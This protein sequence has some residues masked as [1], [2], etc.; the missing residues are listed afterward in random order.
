MT[1]TSPVT[2]K[3]FIDSMFG[4]NAFVV[5]SAN[6]SGGRAGWVID[7]GLGD[8]VQRLLDYIAREGIGLEKIL[9]THGHADHIAGLDAVHEAH[10]HAQVFMADADQPML[11][12]PELNL[13]A[14]F[15]FR[16]VM[17]TPANGDITPRQVMRLG[18]VDW[19]ALDTSGH[20][21]GGRSFYCAEAGVVLTGDA[22]FAGSIGRTDLP[23]S[24]SKQL[25]MNI[26]EQLLT[27]PP[28]TMVYS[29]LGPITTIGNERKLNRFL[30]DAY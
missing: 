23:G 19:T 7:P 10:P 28:E 15:G 24:D 9:L 6:G 4:E 26:H 2:I 27:L 22:L 16:V 12:D 3:A 1:T 18:E 30:S 25:L 14:P 5:S 20:S 29:G 8:Q 21:P 17:E 13:S 11:T